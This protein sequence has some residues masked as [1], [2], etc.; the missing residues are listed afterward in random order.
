MRT[1][2]LLLLLLGLATTAAAQPYEVSWWTADAG[3]AAGLGGG[4]FLL[5]GTCGQPDAGGPFAAASHAV[6]GGYWSLFAGGT[7]VFQAN[8]A[9]TKTDGQAAAVPGL[10]LTY[11]IVVSNAGPDVASGA[12]VTDTLPSA[13][14]GATWTC[15]PSPGASCAASGS[16]SISD[17]VVV[18][19]SGNVTYTLS[20]LVDPGVTGVLANTALVSPPA[21]VTDPVLADN[22]ATDTDTLTPRADLAVTKSDSADPVLSREPLTYTVQVTNLGPSVSPSMTLTDPLPSTLG[23][24]S[25]GPSACAFAG[26]TVSCAL[27]PL[28]PQASTTVTIATRVTPD[29][30]GSLVNSATVTGGAPDPSAANNVASQSTAVLFRAAGEVAHDVALRG[31]LSGL[32]TLADADYYR[33][34][35]QPYASYELVVDEA[36]GDVGPGDGPA[37]D[38]IAADGVSVLQAAVPVGTGPSRSLRLV[39]GSSAAVDDQMVRVRS[40]SCTSGCGADDT[41]RLRAYETTYAVPRFN[42]ASSQVTVVILQNASGVPVNGRMYFWSA[43]GTLV[44]EQPLTLPVHGLY[45]LI[46]STVPALSG[47]SGTATIVHDAPYGQLAGKAVALEPATGFSFDT[48]LVWRAR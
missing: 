31:D 19:A 29:P 3:G 24:E 6:T 14:T 16:G 5:S 44:H 35:Q 27:G 40:R 20:A 22:T 17:N 37:L 48:P 26:G 46:T 8:L 2:A 45:T 10:P 30:I 21:G 34:R 28:A 9:C 7:S 47:Q 42:N 36:S 15:A 13:L 11:T 41:Y 1:S 4:G 18:P 12:G 23:F 25:V 43:A 38:R 33:L 32:A 39:N